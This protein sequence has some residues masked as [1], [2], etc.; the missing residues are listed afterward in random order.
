MFKNDIDIYGGMF[1][2][3]NNMASIEYRTCH[4]LDFDRLCPSHKADYRTVLDSVAFSTAQSK[5]K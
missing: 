4:P 5:E 1:T 3:E 2:M